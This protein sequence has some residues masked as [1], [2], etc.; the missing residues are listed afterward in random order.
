MLSTIFA[1][2][3]LV[4]LGGIVRLTESGLGCPDWPL[5][6]DQIVPPFDMHVLIE[7]THRLVAGVSLILVFSM[8]LIALRYYRQRLW[9]VVPALIAFILMIVQAVL[10]G[11]TVLTELAAEIVVAHFALAQVI[12]AT[13][14]LTFVATSGHIEFRKTISDRGLRIF[15]ITALIVS[16][17]TYGLLLSGSYTTMS[18]ASAACA[19]DWPHCLNAIWPS[20][21]LS[22]IQMF[23]R[24]LSIVCGFML[25]MV[26]IMAWDRRYEK[27]G[28]AGTGI[29]LI[30]LFLA[31]IFIGASSIWMENSV[32]IKIMHLALAT[33]IWMGLISLVFL[34]F[35]SSKPGTGNATA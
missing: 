8:V 15:L 9:I 24:I 5:C 12:L 4:V 21:K 13:M 3:V 28:I 33:I 34:P 7:Y 29:G 32:T 10:G 23:H 22:Q 11:I 27:S 18:G 14:V 16:V 1:V 2:F 25:L 17:F 20:N 30:T 19:G 6:H 35:R 26:S 31:Q